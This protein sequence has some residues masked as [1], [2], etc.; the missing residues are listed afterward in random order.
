MCPNVDEP[1]LLNYLSHQQGQRDDAKE[2]VIAAA[3]SVVSNGFQ[4]SHVMMDRAAAEV[5]ATEHG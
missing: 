3:R 1:S 2:R 5:K 4:P